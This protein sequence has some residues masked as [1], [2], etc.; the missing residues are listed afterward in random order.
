M[1][2]IPSSTKST[3]DYFEDAQF[4]A[5]EDAALDHMTEC[6]EEAVQLHN[7]SSETVQSHNDPSALS[8]SYLSHISL[9]PFDGNHAD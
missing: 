4:E 1:Q 9:P 8:L 5:T 2:P 6:L 7:Q 3:L